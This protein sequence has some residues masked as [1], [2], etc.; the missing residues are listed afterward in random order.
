L[1]TITKNQV[2]FNH[3]DYIADLNFE[4]A[5]IALILPGMGTIGASFTFL[6]APDFERTTEIRPEGTGE[7][8]SS[9]FYAFSL[10]Y[11]RMLTERFAIGGN[12][13]Y[14]REN[15]WHTSSSGFAL[16][17]GVTYRTIFKNIKIGMSISNFGTNMKLEGRNLIIQHDIDE[18]SEG[19]N[20]NI[21]ADLTTDEFSLPIFFRFGMSSNIMADIFN[22]EGQDFIVSVDALHPNDDKEYMNIGAEYV[23]GNLIALRAGYRRLF[24]KED[25]KEGGLT[26]GLGLHYDISQ[27]GITI[28]YAAVDYGRFDYVNKFS[29]IFS[30]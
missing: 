12:F 25:E 26:F 13:K 4:F 29:L 24:I 22:I 2:I 5:G 9:S 6:G 18:S 7:M 14:I 27:F 3:Y 20:A 15:L 16:D 10:G 8:V 11:G 30:F 17:V 23:Y 1:G 19:N 28:D 21:N